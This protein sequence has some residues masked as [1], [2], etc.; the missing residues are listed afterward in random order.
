MSD[1]AIVR[2]VS[3]ASLSHGSEDLVSALGYPLFGYCCP[4]EG[5]SPMIGRRNVFLGPC[6]FK[7]GPEVRLSGLQ[8]HESGIWNSVSLPASIGFSG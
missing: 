5:F 4:S 3:G 2:K 7:S 1:L 6:F 8:H